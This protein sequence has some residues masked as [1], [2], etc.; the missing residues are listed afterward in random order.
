MLQERKKKHFEE[1]REDKIKRTKKKKRNLVKYAE[2]N[3]H[4]AGKETNHSF[5]LGT[6]ETKPA[7]SRRDAAFQTYSISY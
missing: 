2:E 6:D 3:K 7:L 4:E 5:C 1:Y